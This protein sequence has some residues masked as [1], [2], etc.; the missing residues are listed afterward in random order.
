MTSE[1]HEVGVVTESLLYPLNERLELEG[2]DRDLHFHGLIGHGVEYSRV[3][4]FRTFFFSS[5]RCNGRLSAASGNTEYSLNLI[6]FE[7]PLLYSED[8]KP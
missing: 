4:G 3:L 1:R 5:L 2:K 8:I 6:S 7:S